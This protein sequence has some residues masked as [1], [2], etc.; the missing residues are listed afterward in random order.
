MSRPLRPVILGRFG[1]PTLAC[2]R[3]WGRQGFRAGMI[4]VQSP[5]EPPPRSRYLSQCALLP[6]NKLY[7]NEGLSVIIRFLKDFQADGLICINEKIACWLQDNKDEVPPATA[8]WLPPKESI[9]SVLSKECQIDV[10][11]ESGLTVLPTY[12][13]DSSY[14]NVTTIHADHFPL[15]LRP[16]GTIKPYFKVQLAPS[17][18]ALK[19]LLLRL[20]QLSGKIIAQPFKNMPNLVIHG[21]GTADRGI[22]GI[23]SFLVERKFEG[24][25]LTIRPWD[26]PPRLLDQCLTFARNMHL[27]G[28]FHLEFLYDPKSN[29]CYFLEVNNRLGGTTAKVLACGYDEPMLALAAYGAVPVPDLPIKK[30]TVTNRLA[31]VKCLLQAMTNQLSPLDSPQE[32]VIVRFGKTLLAMGLFRDDVVSFDDY[33][34]FLGVYWASISKLFKPRPR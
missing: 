18:H 17:P 32:R 10:A 8:L 16:S 21:I 12:L 13:I 22:L 28:P 29:E 3:S 34:G 31:L 9:Q 20:S 25:T 4:C 14:F 6:R 24:V 27:T 26:I 30:V 2:I 11:R 33:T 1:P 23:Q 5:G 7:T 19:S 15:C